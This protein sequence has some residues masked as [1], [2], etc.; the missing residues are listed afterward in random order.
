MLFFGWKWPRY[1]VADLRARR[2]RC[3]LAACSESQPLSRELFLFLGVPT[4]GLSLLL[5]A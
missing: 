5:L 1:G 4:V 2:H 3:A